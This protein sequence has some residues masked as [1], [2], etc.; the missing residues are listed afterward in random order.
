MNEISLRLSLECLDNNGDTEREPYEY[1]EA[2]L[3]CKNVLIV[4]KETLETAK[5]ILRSK[6]YQ[7]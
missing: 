6:I 5:E 7:N 4:K 3:V 1:M 2:K